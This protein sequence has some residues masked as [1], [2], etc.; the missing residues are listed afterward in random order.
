MS[1]ATLPAAA[2]GVVSGTVRV[3]GSKSE[4]NRALVLAALADG[5]GRVLGGLASRDC[6]L[7]VAALSGFGVTVD[8][9]SP[10]WLVT[11][12]QKFV[13]GS[14]VDCG[15]AGT[16]MRFVPPIALLADGPTRFV[17]DPHASAR[18]MAGLLDGLR[19]LGADIDA[20]SLPFTLTPGALPET[21]D[22]TIDASASSQF[23]S[24]PLLVGARLAGGLTVRHAG[25]RVPSTPHI[26]MT[27]RFLQQRGVPARA[28][29][30]AAWHVAPGPIHA[31]DV[32]VEPDL[33]NAAAFLAAALV[34]GGRVSVVGW[35]ADSQQ[36]GAMFLDIA[37]TLGGTVE[38]TADAVTLTGPQRL[39]P[40][41]V[42]LHAASEL[43]PVVAAVAALADGTSRIRGVAHIRGHETDRLAALTTELTRLGIRVAETQDGLRILGG[44][45]TLA[46]EPF[47]SYAD[48]RMVHAAAILALRTPGLSV[49]DVACVSKTMP[50]FTDRWS[51]MVGH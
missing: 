44:T 5:P 20:D 24:G 48:H 41:D 47:R 2:A 36:P 15:L 25:S 50:D 9:S 26:E 16:V 17:G 37:R 8:Q 3:P 19:Q 31:C 28:I 51:Q 23:I 49:D 22:I 21:A 38:A 42:D 39:A 27:L 1:Q 11:P 10:A 32:S 6:D 7:M 46:A 13:G 43:T 34:T 33:T 29:G 30:P 12:P 40:I 14:Q 35:P 18:P 4:T 45:P